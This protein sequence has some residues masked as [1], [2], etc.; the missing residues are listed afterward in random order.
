MTLQPSRRLYAVPQTWPVRLEIAKAIGALAAQEEQEHFQRRIEIAAVRGDCEDIAEVLRNAC[1]ECLSVLRSELRKAGYNPSEP[2]VPAGSPDGGQWTEEDGGTATLGDSN[3]VLSDAMSDNNWIPGA[4]Y[5]ADAPPVIGHNQGPPLEE[6]PEIPPKVLATKQ[7]IYDFLKAAAYWLEEASLVDKRAA[8]LFFI[9]LMG[10]AW[11]AEKYLPYII[12]YQDPPRSLQELQQAAL[13][14]TSQ[15]YNDHHLVE[16]KAAADDGF[17]ASMIDGPEN[18]VRI[19]TLKHWLI[20]GWYQ[21][22][23]G[24]FDDVSPREYLRGRSW[25]DRVRVGTQA[26]IRFGV[27]K[28]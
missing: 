4:R 17:P 6:P 20:T 10:A 7:T 24:S 26:L 28:P 8:T 1:R 2:R 22:P 18:I 27:M 11:V 15:Y 3:T 5:A 13:L 16:K 21:I 19:P 23:N 25:E 14:P 9:A 12:T